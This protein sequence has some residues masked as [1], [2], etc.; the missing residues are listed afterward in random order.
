M[1]TPETYKLPKSYVRRVVHRYLKTGKVR[2]FH[3]VKGPG[4]QEGYIAI[5]KTEEWQRQIDEQQGRWN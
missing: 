1:K 5:T 3:L 2:R 4:G